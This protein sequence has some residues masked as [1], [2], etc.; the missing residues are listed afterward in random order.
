MVGFEH[1]DEAERFLG[2]L[3]ERL[4]KFGLTLHPEK[5]RLI[6]FGRYAFERR[7][8]R[9]EGKPE[10]FNFLGFTHMCG[11]SRK[12]G[13]RVE[14]HTMRQRFCAKLKELAQELK[15][16]RHHPIPV[17]GIWLRS[18]LRG[19]FRY[20][21]VPFNSRALSRFRS[22]VIRLWHWHLCRRSQRGYV[23][24]SR[25]ATIVKRWIPTAKIYHPYPSE[26]LRVRIQGRS[27]VR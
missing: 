11:K 2:E 1:R 5:T 6:E 18:V 9:G 15:R 14:R 26:R 24:W 22:R 10:T 16:R 8:R 17:V 20:Y 23:R 27:P 13:F 4:G 25:M 12:G 7:Q 19:H 3:K 21:G